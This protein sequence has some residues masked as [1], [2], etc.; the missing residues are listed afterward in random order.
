MARNGARRPCW[1]RLACMHLANAAP[2]G[3]DLAATLAVV[4]AFTAAGFSLLGVFVNARMTGRATHD[5]WRRGQV[6]P[7][8]AQLLIDS[9]EASR[10]W[11]AACAQ[12]VREAQGVE[13]TGPNHWEAFGVLVRKIRYEVAQ[14]ELVAGPRLRFNADALYRQ[15][16]EG[17]SAPSPLLSPQPPLGLDEIGEINRAT[18]RARQS[19]VYAARADLGVARKAVRLWHNLVVKASRW[20]VVGPWLRAL[21]AQREARRRLAAI[22][23]DAIGDDAQGGLWPRDR[24]P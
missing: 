6:Q 12:S 24:R 22:A 20:P 23:E 21:S 17:L 1:V 16:W 5:Q 7:L 18:E 13:E 11:E 3:S 8:V 14:L 15:H 2:S 10:E 9:Q 19:L 4:A